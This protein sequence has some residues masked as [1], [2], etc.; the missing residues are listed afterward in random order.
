M[1]KFIS[2]LIFFGTILWGPWWLT[3]ALA[4]F[5]LALWKSSATLIIGGMVADML[6][7]VPLAP[8]FNITFFYTLLFGFL[9]IIERYLRARLLD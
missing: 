4:V 7:N 8:L 6:F 9:I 3:V 1:M 5:L 2:T